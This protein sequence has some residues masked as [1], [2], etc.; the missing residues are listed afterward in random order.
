MNAILFRR[1]YELFSFRHKKVLNSLPKAHRALALATCVKFK[2]S[3][4]KKFRRYEKMNAIY[5]LGEDVNS[6]VFSIRR[7]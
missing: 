7:Y 2:V 1:G 6:S 4:S 3:Y 5:S